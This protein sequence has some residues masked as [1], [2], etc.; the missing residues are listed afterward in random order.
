MERKWQEITY[1]YA[2]GTKKHREH[3]GKEPMEQQLKNNR[4]NKQTGTNLQ[5]QQCGDK[6]SESIVEER[7]KGKNVHEQQSRNKHAGTRVQEHTS[8]NNSTDTNL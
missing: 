8:R 4:R 5:K 6:R 2:H 1:R 7:A 3:S